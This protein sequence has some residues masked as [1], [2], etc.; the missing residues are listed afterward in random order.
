MQLEDYFD[1]L[2]P[3]DI[4]IKGHR[5]GIET[6]LYEYI[7]RERTAEQIARTYSTPTLEHVYA[8]ILYYLRNKA[9]VNK[10]M[11]DWLEFG[12]RAREEQRRSHPEFVEK[13]RRRREE[14][15]AKVF[16]GDVGEAQ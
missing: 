2:D 8:T 6:V 3:N 13:M 7:C 12:Q 5:I 15:E 16:I 10:Y 1:F 14:Q 9:A 11:A 4:R